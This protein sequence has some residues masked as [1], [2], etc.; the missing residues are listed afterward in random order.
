MNSNL[1][2]YQK[3]FMLK[4]KFLKNLQLYCTKKREVNKIWAHWL[5]RILSKSIVNYHLLGLIKTDELDP[6]IIKH[7]EQN[8]INNKQA[9]DIYRQLV[10]K[11]HK[12]FLEYSS[13][14]EQLL[15][16][17]NK[18][19]K[20]Q[21]RIK[22]IKSI[23]MSNVLLL[24][25][26]GASFEIKIP[27]DK[28]HKI[29]KL[30]NG[31]NNLCLFYLF[32]HYFNYY[33]LDG[34]SLQW[35]IP[36]SVFD[37]LISIGLQGEL[38][39]SPTNHHHQQYWS[40]FYVDCF[41]GSNGNFYSLVENQDGL[42][43]LYEINPPFIEE[44]FATSCQ[45]IIDILN[46]TCLPLGFIYIMPNWENLLGYDLLTESEY[47]LGEII[48]KKNHHCYFQSSNFNYIVASFDTV[49]L[50]IGNKLFEQNNN[51]QTILRNVSDKFSIEV[52]LYKNIQGISSQV[53]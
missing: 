5:I 7:M 33:L 6:H 18:L 21:K 10:Q 41:F 44:I 20:F 46:T 1:E 14:H 26:E 53:I 23:N 36:N 8:K 42:G 25:L 30:Y 31:P 24:S 4:K 16:D 9:V 11:Y 32:E 52:N 50:L 40:L 48:V 49:I 35:S 28:Y 29:E 38:F 47:H 51:C 37:Y 43:G 22:C 27:I 17:T 39:S 3:I 34:K 13:Q 2:Y 12:L 45:I 15:K 19:E